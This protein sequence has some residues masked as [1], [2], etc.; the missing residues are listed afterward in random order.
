[1]ALREAAFANVE[2]GENADLNVVPPK[3]ED[4]GDMTGFG[5]EMLLLSLCSAQ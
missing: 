5:T 1:M 3:D 2:M 4:K